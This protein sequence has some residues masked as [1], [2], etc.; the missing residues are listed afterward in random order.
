MNT[1]QKRAFAATFPVHVGVD[2]A[3]TFHKLVAR[4]PDGQRGKAYKVLVSRDGFEA[5]DEYLR[6]LF[7]DVAPPQMLVGLEFAGH[8][9]FTFAHFLAQRGYAV[10]NVLAAHTKASKELEDNNPRKD[11]AKDAAQICRL[12]G[13]GI[14]VRF[15]FLT[16]P[17]VELRLLTVHRHRLTVEATRYKNRLQGL[18]DL[19]WPE[20]MGQFSNLHKATPR[21]ILE[22][23]PLPQDLLAASIRTVRKEIHAASRGHVS[24]EQ[25]DALIASARTSIALPDAA[26][27]RR[28]EIQGLLAR[29]A[30]VRKQLAVLEQRITAL[31][32]G[33]PEAKILTSVPEV[34]AVCA[35]TI[36]AELGTP[37]DY[38]H[39]RQ[40][41]KLAGMNLASRSSGQSEGR[42]WQS[43][44]GRPMLRRQL[45]LL[46]GRWCLTRGLYHQDYLALK[47]R[48]G[49]VGTKAVCTL[50]RKLVPLLLKVMQSGE[51]FDKQRWLENR[52]IKIAS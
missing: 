23:W 5:A 51:P 22:R 37:K 3:K 39:Y 36:V 13:D 20:F 50:A 28:L 16:H 43:K 49:G 1:D 12:V 14:Y 8:H 6:T 32:E 24:R 26:P 44:R 52:Y 42:K 35:A 48:N 15:P 38:A 17:Y 21:A 19:A 4:G 27:E 45:F 46:A 47:A 2:T 33:C 25:M 31:V 9:G 11:D 40:V 18:L 41:L 29:W 10:V 7:P 30:M 34:S